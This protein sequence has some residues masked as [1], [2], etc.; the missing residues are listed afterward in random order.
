MEAVNFIVLSPFFGGRSAHPVVII[1]EKNGERIIAA[2][3]PFPAVIT[4]Y[5]RN[6]VFVAVAS[7]TLKRCNSVAEGVGFEPRG[8]PARRII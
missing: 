1:F 4:G 7:G 8:A 5:A 3:I 6:S 2:I